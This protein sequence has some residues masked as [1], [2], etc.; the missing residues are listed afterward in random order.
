[1]NT[2]RLFWLAFLGVAV[3][4]A[5]VPELFFSESEE[6]LPGA[7]VLTSQANQGSLAELRSGEMPAAAASAAGIQVVV[8]HADLFAPHNWYVA[9]P[10][11]TPQA[12]APRV[13]LPPPAPIA[14]PLPF[15][16]IGKLD[17]S[18]EVQIFLQNGEQL[19]TV[20]VGDVIDNTYRVE[21]IQQALMTL[22]YLPLHISQSLAVGSEL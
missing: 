10:A 12:L 2:R 1:M 9:P 6:A 22:T 18:G 20:R 7:P 11:L 5:V 21:V 16:F 17:N 3:A 13:S 8:P 4:L 15:H 14:P 19:Y